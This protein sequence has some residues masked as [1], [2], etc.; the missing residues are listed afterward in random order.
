MTTA[1]NAQ[2]SAPTL[3][4]RCSTAPTAS[5]QAAQINPFP[6]IRPKEFRELLTEY[7]VPDAERE[8]LLKT[9]RWSLPPAASGSLIRA[10]M[11]EPSTSRPIVS[12]TMP[13]G[14]CR[15]T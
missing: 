13:P 1:Q 10:A 12:H 15:L 8:A 6:A 7:G 9:N 3:A 4:A 14:K 11:P 5:A 2:L